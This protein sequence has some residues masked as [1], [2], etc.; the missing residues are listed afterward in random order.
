MFFVSI[1][2]SRITACPGMPMR[3]ICHILCPKQNSDIYTAIS[4]DHISSEMMRYR[5]RLLQKTQ[6]NPS[7]IIMEAGRAHQKGRVCGQ[8]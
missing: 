5:C 7:H 3:K 2:H 4:K 6:D 8:P 1:R